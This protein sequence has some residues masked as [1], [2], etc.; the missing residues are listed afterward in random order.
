MEC[1]ALTGCY[2]AKRKCFYGS[3]QF[4]LL[5]SESGP[6]LVL[7]H[8]S[9][10]AERRYRTCRYRIRRKNAPLCFGRLCCDD[11]SP[12]WSFRHTV[13][14][15]FWCLRAGIIAVYLPDKR[16][17]LLGNIITGFFTVPFTI[18]LNSLTA[19]FTPFVLSPDSPAITIKAQLYESDETTE[20]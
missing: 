11:N 9:Y 2:T 16:E 14:C 1:A 20:S 15:R 8:R 6:S 13:F 7:P 12:G 5:Q 17:N 10:G 3:K 18:K 4:M 19:F